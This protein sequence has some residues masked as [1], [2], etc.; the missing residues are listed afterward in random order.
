MKWWI[1][2]NVIL[3]LVL[4]FGYFYLGTE[5]EKGKAPIADG[6]NDFLI[7]LGAK[8]KP[9]GVPSLS[10]QYRLDVAIDYLKNMNMF[11]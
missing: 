11:K 3:V 7:I 6:S 8:V 2:A 9:S 1:G 5:I 4:G 10:L